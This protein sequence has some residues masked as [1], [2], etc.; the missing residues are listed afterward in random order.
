MVLVPRCRRA[1]SVEVKR[2]REGGVGRSCDLAGCWGSF[3]GLKGLWDEG[4]EGRGVLSLGDM[5]S[6]S[7][8]AG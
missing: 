5:V 3:G 6:S 1:A 2:V 8:G 4:K 7:A